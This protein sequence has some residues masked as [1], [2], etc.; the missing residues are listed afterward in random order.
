MT[1][2][3]SASLAA[4]SAAGLRVPRWTLIAACTPPTAVMSRLK[5]LEAAMATGDVLLVEPDG[6]AEAPRG[7]AADGLEDEG[8]DE[9][10][11][12]DDGDCGR[13]ELRGDWGRRALSIVDHVMRRRSQPRD[14]CIRSDH[15]NGRIGLMLRRC[16][17][18]VAYVE[19]SA[20]HPPSLLAAQLRGSVP[21]PPQPEPSI[22]AT[23]QH[24]ESETG[25]HSTGDELLVRTRAGVAD[26][27]LA[28]LWSAQP[29][30]SN[31]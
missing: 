13:I 17:P 23:F 9:D 4:L 7:G 20:T 19:S 5:E 25:P 18:V 14:V 26:W 12:D 11:D 21:P 6:H 22:A 8:D 2:S 1:S 28:L 15:S 24:L 27:G 10:G 30:S 3:R 29:A 31:Q 16:P